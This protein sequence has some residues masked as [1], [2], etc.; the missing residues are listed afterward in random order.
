MIDIG[1]R[2][3]RVQ[4]YRKEI[5][6]FQ[7]VAQTRLSWVARQL[8]GSKPVGREVKID[9]QTMRGRGDDSGRYLTLEQHAHCEARGR[10]E[11]LIK[12]ATSSFTWLQRLPDDTL[13][14]LAELLRIADYVPVTAPEDLAQQEPPK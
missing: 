8:C 10:A 9:K 14:R 12:S 13:N 5:E 4:D 6:E 1:T 2:L 3:L 11:D 7:V